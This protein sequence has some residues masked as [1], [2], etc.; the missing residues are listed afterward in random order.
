MVSAQEQRILDA[1]T[2]RLR[3]TFKLNG[4]IVGPQPPPVQPSSQEETPA[5]ADT[6]NGGTG[7]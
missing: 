4:K 6:G 2:V 1:V 3:K 7:R 5:P